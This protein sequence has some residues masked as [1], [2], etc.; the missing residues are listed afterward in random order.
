MYFFYLCNYIRL[1]FLRNLCT[2]AVTSARVTFSL[3]AMVLSPLPFTMPVFMQAATC[4]KR[5][6]LYRWP[7]WISRMDNA[8]LTRSMS[9]KGCSP[10][11]S[12]CEGFF[13]RINNEMFYG[14]SC[15]GVSI[16]QFIDE[17]YGYLLWYNEK[18]IKITLG[19]K[20]P[21]DYRH[22]IGLQ[23]RFVQ[24]NVRV[25]ISKKHATGVLF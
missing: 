11:S 14:R 18:R 5:N 3:G 9:K 4:L 6:P 8:G 19:A 20:R 7:G 25:P 1:D 2:I 16:Q 24:K 12:A 17:L 23:L 15:Q 21:V 13:V 22:S 10:D